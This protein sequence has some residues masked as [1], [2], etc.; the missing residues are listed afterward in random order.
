[1]EKLCQD[2]GALR[3]I[4]LTPRG[5]LFMNDT[6]QILEADLWTRGPIL[7]DIVTFAVLL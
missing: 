3:A 1:M 2:Q 5:N 7:A 6:L 4:G